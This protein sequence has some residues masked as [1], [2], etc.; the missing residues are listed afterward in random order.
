MRIGV[1]CFPL[2]ADVGGVKQYFFRLFEELLATDEENTYTFFHFPQNA[3][4]LES[5]P[6]PRWR[7]GSVFLQDQGEIALHLTGLD[8]YFCP[9]CALWPR[10][11]PLPSVVTL[12]DIQEV[13]YPEYF[14]PLDRASRAYHYPGSTRMATR[15]ITISAF[16]KE[17]IV[18]H[19]RIP[20]DKVRAIH[21]CAD[22]RLCRVEEVAR[23]P[24]LDLPAEGF[25]F[26]PAN[27]WQHKN[28]D[29][30]LRALRRLKEER[31][32]RIPAVFTGYDVANGYPLMERAAA[33]G[34]GD[35]VYAVGYVPEEELAWLYRQARMMVFPSLFEGFG[36]P[37]VEAMMVGCPVATSRVTSLPEIGQDAVAYFD[38]WEPESIAAVIE[39]LWTN[40][41]ERETLVRRGKERARAFS[42]AAMAM[43]HREVFR[44]AAAAFS[45]SAYVWHH[46]VYRHLHKAAIYWKYRDVL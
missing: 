9:F 10:P 12:V 18:T 31:G 6:N 19:H 36:I 20:S 23:P 25:V 7:E 17:S 4:E 8:L 28:H 32:L 35:Q 1:N 41:S 33:Y 15:V 34:L 14:T 24:A 37:V 38:P 27:R 3:E 42:A 5:F 46:L 13:F 39:R 26:Y 40:P 22:K 11:V 30:L 43:A 29:A 16:S 44:E 21:L 45:Y 2:C